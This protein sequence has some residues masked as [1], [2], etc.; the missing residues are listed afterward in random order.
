MPH[1]RS[2]WLG[3]AAGNALS[4]KCLAGPSQEAWR[5]SFYLLPRYPARACIVMQRPPA[6]KGACVGGWK[7]GFGTFFAPEKCIPF[8]FR[9]P[10]PSLLQAPVSSSPGPTVRLKWAPRPAPSPVPQEKMQ[11]NSMPRADEATPGVDG[12]GVRR[13]GE[14]CRRLLGG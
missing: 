11:R 7:V 10:S 4:E 2:R 13:L 9:L 8:L 3:G 5:L 14:E 1:P 6:A 12:R